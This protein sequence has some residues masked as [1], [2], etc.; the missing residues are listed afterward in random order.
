MRYF[1]LRFPEGKFKALTLSYDDGVRADERFSKTLNRYGIKCT[2]NINSAFVGVGDKLTY[3]ELQTLLIDCGHEVA[4][5]GER[6]MA[7]G[8]VPP[9]RGMADVINC[10]L[11]LERELGRIVRGMA[12]PDTGVT[13]MFNGNSYETIRAYLQA[14][15]ITYSRTLGGDNNSFS[16]PDD[17]YQWMPTAHHQNPKLFDWCDEFLSMHEEDVYLTRRHPKLFYLWGHSY[18]FDRNNNWERL[19]EFCE[20]MS[21]QEDVWYATNGEIYDYITAYNSLVMSADCTRVYNPTL[22][23][24]WFFADGK[25]YS[26]E[27]GETITVD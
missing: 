13:R 17:W 24:I 12:Y 16:L 9:V 5:H 3:E 23:K 18:E 7:P 27:P 11:T 8:I 10:R 4:V 6:H 14:A 2:F 1:F 25:Q 22:R 19:E 15:G 26:I 21:G 20:R